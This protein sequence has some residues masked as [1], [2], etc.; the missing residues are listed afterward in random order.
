MELLIIILF[1]NKRMKKNWK[2]IL[3]YIVR[4]IELIITGAAGG[5][6]GGNL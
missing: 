1:M 4:I 5:M 6:I 3:L 2:T